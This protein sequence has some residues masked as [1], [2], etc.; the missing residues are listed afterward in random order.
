MFINK[1]PSI[2]PTISPPISLSKVMK[3]SL[4][5][6]TAPTKKEAKEIAMALLEEGLIACAN[7]IPDVES[8]FVWEG[9]ITASSEVVIIVK[10]RP[11]NEKKIIRLVKEMHSYDCP[12]ITFMSIING[13]PDFLKWVDGSC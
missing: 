4:G 13:N 3:L 9:Q 8:F 2:S 12:C 11:V 10:T 5:Y 7:I 6:I 1:S